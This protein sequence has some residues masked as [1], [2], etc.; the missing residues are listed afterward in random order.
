MIMSQRVIVSKKGNT[1]IQLIPTNPKYDP[2]VVNL[3]DSNFRVIG[4]FKK[5]INNY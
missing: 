4:I 3:Q 1:F 5:A 2:I